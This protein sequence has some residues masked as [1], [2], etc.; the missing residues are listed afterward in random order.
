MSPV[1]D[2]RQRVY[3]VH[4]VGF[5]LQVAALALESLGFNKYPQVSCGLEDTDF[6]KGKVDPMSY[7][8]PSVIKI[9]H[10]SLKRYIPQKIHTS[11]LEH[12]YT[13]RMQ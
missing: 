7:W 8:Q 1:K 4:R 9:V 2:A 13:Y 6:N 5:R 10:N 12:K 11:S 3:Q